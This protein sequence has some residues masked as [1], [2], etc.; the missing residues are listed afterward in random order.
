MQIETLKMLT[1]AGKSKRLS[2][3][4]L[5]FLVSA[6]SA[7]GLIGSFSSSSTSK[8]MQPML[9]LAAA[10]ATATATPFQPL[11]P[12][13]TYL[14]TSF[15]VPI[16]EFSPSQV[17]IEEG[18][19]KSWADYAGPT[20][21]PDIDIPAPTGIFSQPQGQVNIL[22]LGSDQRPNTG[23]FRT[24]T[25]IL[26][27][28]NPAQGTANLTSFPRDLYV[29]IPGWTINRINT[30]FAFGGFESL[31]TTFE[32]NFGVHPDYYVLINFWSFED[33]IDNLGG[34]DVEI[35]KP[36]CD[37]RD[38][39][40]VYCVSES[41]E[42]MD[43][44]TTLWYVRSRYSSSDFDRGRRQ[45]EVVRAGFKKLL[46]LNGIT[47]APE[48]YEI[49]Q[50]NV[51]TDITFDVVASLLPLAARLGDNER[52]NHYFIGPAQVYN[53]VNYS[54][55]YVLIPIRDAVLEVMRQALNSPD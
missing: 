11:D 8:S 19:S 12:T 21:W 33:V 37:H 6:C 52:I 50:Q 3:I 4:I 29:Y 38:K 25:I 55:A 5:V 49:Y 48:L 17:P 28:L 51:T 54:G 9:I 41:I 30:A 32:Y 14:P 45:Q 2:I 26:L 40:G 15:P 34:I 53:Y 35:A 22:L 23:G 36:L 44:E 47:R 7:S 16:L 10:D 42:H 24:D 46:T 1:S 13:P 39:Y 20:V 31:A 27:T 43:G 18:R